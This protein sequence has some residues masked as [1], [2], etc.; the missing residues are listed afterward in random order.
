[1]QARMI[2]TSAALAAMLMAAPVA[3]AEEPAPEATPAAEAAPAPGAEAEPGAPAAEEFPVSD[4]EARMR[5]HQDRIRAIIERRRAEAAARGEA[6]PAEADPAAG[7]GDGAT[8]P[9]PG[10]RRDVPTREE[11]MQ[12]HQSRVREIIERRRQE[13]LYS[14]TSWDSLFQDTLE[15]RALEL[16]R[17]LAHEERVAI[18][19][20]LP[21]PFDISGE[22][23]QESLPRPAE[24]D[25][26]VRAYREFAEAWA[27]F[28][29]AEGTPAKLEDALGQYLAAAAQPADGAPSLVLELEE[30]I[31]RASPF[32]DHVRAGWDPAKQPQLADALARA[33]ADPR[34]GARAIDMAGFRDRMPLMREALR[35]QREGEMGALT[36]EEAEACVLAMLNAPELAALARELGVA[37]NS[38]PIATPDQPA[39]ED[40]TPQEP[41]P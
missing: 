27:A 17:V 18:A 41:T 33:A 24:R 4:R 9:P 14:P 5:E 10:A 8:E 29:V 13:R 12:D 38:A 37:P 19:E 16:G 26:A 6:V 2:A 30:R 32:L 34:P 20:S 1:M 36:S 39:A 15:R 23:S 21:P 11:R 7:E 40:P 28:L 25:E 31:Q 35:K 22:S 3:P